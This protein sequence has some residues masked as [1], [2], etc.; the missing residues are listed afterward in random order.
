MNQRRICIGVCV[1]GGYTMPTY[2]VDKNIQANGN[3]KVHKLGCNNLPKQMERI[4]LG[5]FTVSNN[6]IETARK[7]YPQVEGCNKCCD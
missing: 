5:S 1:K 2:Y 3:H 4:Y 6:A 7:Y